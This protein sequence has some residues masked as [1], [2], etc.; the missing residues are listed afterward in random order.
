M[1]SLNFPT[2]FIITLGLR[3]NTMFNILWVFMLYK[4]FIILTCK[5]SRNINLNPMEMSAMALQEVHH[6]PDSSTA[7]QIE[8]VCDHNLISQPLSF[9][10][11]SKVGFLKLLKLNFTSIV[12]I[13]L[14]LVHCEKIQDQRIWR[15]NLLRLVAVANHFCV[16]SNFY[17]VPSVIWNGT[18]PL[19]KTKHIH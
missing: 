7:T 12:V 18:R 10:S 17:D 5:R 4:V 11:L 8:V 2:K 16:S 1:T 14:Q 13:L 19:E 6:E 3:M 9:A 15:S